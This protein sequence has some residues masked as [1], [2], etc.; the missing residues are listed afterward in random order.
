MPLHR[1]LDA[2]SQARSTHPRAMR[3]LLTGQVD[4]LGDGHLAKRHHAA[5]PAGSSRAAGGGGGGGGGWCWAIE[6]LPQ[7]QAVF[8]Q[9]REIAGIAGPPPAKA[10]RAGAPSMATDRILIEAS[11]LQD[12]SRP[13]RLRGR[14]GGERCGVKAA[15]GPSARDRRTMALVAAAA[16]R[17]GPVRRSSG[18]Q[19]GR[20]PAAAACC[21]AGVAMALNSDWATPL[22]ARG[23]APLF[24]FLAKRPPQTVLAIHPARR[25]VNWQ[26]A[27]SLRP[28]RSQAMGRG[29]RQPAGCSRA[30]AFA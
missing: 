29:R 8:W 16:N 2:S 15:P 4:G 3:S 7:P 17:A 28:A 27:G 30:D 20:R 19:A 13:W 6:G 24:P 11:R 14:E 10:H 18:V 22:G 23:H 1:M 25:P 21:K 26:G 12:G 5:L 9:P